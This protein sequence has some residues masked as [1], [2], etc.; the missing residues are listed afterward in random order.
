MTDK[1][2]KRFIKNLLREKRNERKENMD[3]QKDA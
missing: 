3:S 1:D 2:Y